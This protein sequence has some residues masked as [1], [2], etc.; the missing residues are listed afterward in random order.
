MKRI[1]SKKRNLSP[2]KLGS[3]VHNIHPNVDS[4]SDFADVALCAGLPMETAI[5]TFTEEKIKLDSKTHLVMTTIKTKG[6]I[7]RNNAANKL[8]NHKILDKI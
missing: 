1:S 4:L 2:L 7:E 3:I 6:K 8:G 5:H